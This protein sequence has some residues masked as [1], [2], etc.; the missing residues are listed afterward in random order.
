MEL[1]LEPVM[2]LPGRLDPSQVPGGVDDTCRALAQTRK[3]PDWFTRRTLAKH[4]HK[5]SPEALLGWVVQPR[6][7]CRVHP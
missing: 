5:L 3:G 1:L 6:A 2:Q 7:Q 4:L